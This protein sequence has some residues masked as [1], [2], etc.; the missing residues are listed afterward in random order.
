MPAAH[1]SLQSLLESLFD[2]PELRI[3]LKRLP[4]DQG[5]LGDLRGP[6][7]RLSELVAE[8]IDLLERL[9]RLDAAFFAELCAV[10][11]HRREDIER[12]AREWM[13]AARPAAAAASGTAVAP[14]RADGLGELVGYFEDRAEGA[15]K[16]LNRLQRSRA[17]RS[18]IADFCALHTRHLESLRGG[19]LLRAHHILREIVDLEAEVLRATGAAIAMHVQASEQAASRDLEFLLQCLRGYHR[20]EAGGPAATAEAAEAVYRSILTARSRTGRPTPGA[21]DRG[22]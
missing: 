3:F 11:P 14:V 16:A 7:I 6:P 1:A 12:T 15:L 5:Q 19:Q 18:F 8:A 17:T 4:D 22:S 21:A 2:E 13:S 10:R 9:G 20:Q